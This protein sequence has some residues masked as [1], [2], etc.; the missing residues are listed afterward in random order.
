MDCQVVADKDGVEYLRVPGGFVIC[1]MPRDALHE[2]PE[3]Y[4]DGYVVGAVAAWG[5]LRVHHHGFRAEYAQI[6]A[7][8]ADDHLD[9][10]AVVETYAVPLVPRDLLKLE[11]ERHGQGLP[12]DIRPEKLKSPAALWGA[13][14]AWYGSG[15]VFTTNHTVMWQWGPA[16]TVTPAPPK[17]KRPASRFERKQTNRQGPGGKRRGPKNIAPRGSR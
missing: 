1:L 13:Q 16:A 3:P 8:V 14:A 15:N 17:S 7:L 12:V 2:P 6:V 5:D 4:G 11:A 9:L 10:R